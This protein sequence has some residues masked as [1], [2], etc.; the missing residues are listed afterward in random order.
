MDAGAKDLGISM[1]LR[2]VLLNRMYMKGRNSSLEFR[3]III[4]GPSSV[5]ACVFIYLGLGI[6]TDCCLHVLAA[7]QHLDNEKA[8]YASFGDTTRK[9]RS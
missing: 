1:E 9:V 4:L 7:M 5:S 2:P 8:T 3:S 6:L